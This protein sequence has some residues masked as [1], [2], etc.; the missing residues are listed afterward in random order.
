MSERTYTEEEVAAIY[1]RVA[2]RERSASTRDVS[3]G[4]T[5]AEVEQAGREAGLDPASIRAAAAEL[6]AG[7]RHPARS[8]VAVA[9]RWIEAPL[10]VGAWEDLVASLRHQFG[11]NTSWS[12]KDTASL[13]DAQEWTHNSMSGVHTTV[14]LSPREGRTL[15]RVVQEGAGLED[16]RMMG[17]LMA[18]FLSLIPAMLAG[19]LVAETLAWGDVA[20]VAAVVL[21]LLTGT[22]IGGPRLAARERNSRER[23][24]GHVQEIADDLSNQLVAH[25]QTA[26]GDSAPPLEPRLDLTALTASSPEAEGAPTRRRTRS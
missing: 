17:W 18:A 26:P 20:G 2:E 13:G 15:L 8:K 14:T 1:A 19:A 7:Y 21:V 3:A 16:E 12:G 5:L 23:L 11:S 9:E 6:D 4:L 24:T 22:A 25:R 10:P